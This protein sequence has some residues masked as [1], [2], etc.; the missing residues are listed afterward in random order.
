MPP[1]GIVYILWLPPLP[2]LLWAPPRTAAC[3]RLRRLH[4]YPAR[5]PCLPH[6][7]PAIR[8]TTIITTTE[9]MRIPLSSYLITL[10]LPAFYSP[11]RALYFTL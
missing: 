10:A 3:T 6:L 5:A 4:Y 11:R 7:P 8:N 9:R 2:A 1:I